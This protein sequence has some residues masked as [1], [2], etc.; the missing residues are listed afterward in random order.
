MSV[1]PARRLSGRRAA[2]DQPR[3]AH[4]QAERRPP[5]GP[6]PH[7]RA[8][9]A[10]CGSSSRSSTPTAR[11]RCGAARAA[12]SK[13]RLAARREDIEE[14][15]GGMSVLAAGQI[16]DR[17]TIEGG[18]T[19]RSGVIVATMVKGGPVEAPEGASP[20]KP[21][22]EIAAQFGRNLA[23]CRRQ[24]GLSQEELG[25]RAQIHRT[26]VSLLERGAAHPSSR[27]H[28]QARR[29]HL[30]PR[31]RVA[32]R[33]RV[34][35]PTASRS[36]RA[37][38]RSTGSPKR[39]DLQGPLRPEPRPLP[40]A[41]RAD[42]GGSRGPRLPRPRHRLETR[43]ARSTS[44]SSTC[45]SGSPGRSR[46]NRPSCSTASPTGRASSAWGRV[47]TRSTARRRARYRRAAS[48]NEPRPGT[49]RRRS[50]EPRRG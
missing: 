11:A 2:R 34:G 12:W 24:A 21:S 39:R 10:S 46:S 16:S 43:G 1:G 47:A 40:Q 22:A 36:W 9:H 19:S 31:G 14:L 25:Y 15:R 18:H 35:R 30:G 28:R 49:D 3:R 27:H 26:E 42:P 33:P 38:S 45:S 7:R 32:G 23:R 4:R 41:R 20:L 48:D 37:A 5:G 29:R 17:W 44:R 13:S 50:A 8:G 6:Q